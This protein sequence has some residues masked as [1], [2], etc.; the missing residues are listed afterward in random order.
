MNKKMFRIVDD[1]LINKDM[2]SENFTSA[3]LRIQR[4][5]VSTYLEFDDISHIFRISEVY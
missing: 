2:N 3:G 1:H 4:S 5:T